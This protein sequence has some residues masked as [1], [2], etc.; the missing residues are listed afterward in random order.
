[1]VIT[2]RIEPFYRGLFYRDPGPPPCIAA[3]P[4]GEDH[5]IES[6]R[7]ERTQSRRYILIKF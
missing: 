4:E 5:W 2:D 1:M 3:S 7:F 6:R